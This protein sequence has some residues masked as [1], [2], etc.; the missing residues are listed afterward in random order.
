MKENLKKIKTFTETG[1]VEITD[2]D[3][4]P[5]DEY[6][7]K[8]SELLQSSNISILQTSSGCLIIRPSKISS[9]LVTEE[10]KVKE[11]KKSNPS[12]LEILED[13]ERLEE[14]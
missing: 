13:E 2:I 6:S 7:K 9:I 14:E 12:K 4:T 1:P 5:L 8:L 11:T 3:S 10:K